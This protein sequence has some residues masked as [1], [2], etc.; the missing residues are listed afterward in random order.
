MI[1]ILRIVLFLETFGCL[2]IWSGL[3]FSNICS[4]FSILI[5]SCASYFITSS[6]RT[7]SWHPE[8]KKQGNFFYSRTKRSN[9]EAR[10]SLNLGNF[11]L[12]FWGF[13]KDTLK[14]LQSRVEVIWSRFEGVIAKL[15]CPPS[16]LPRLQNNDFFFILERWTR[17]H[18][19]IYSPDLKSF[20]VILGKLLQFWGFHKFTL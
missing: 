18:W 20:G 6:I 17:V 12:I 2:L 16:L 5:F 8:D 3:L 19:F 13:I 1:I 14:L 11:F 15:G 7:W 4:I 10:I 9:C